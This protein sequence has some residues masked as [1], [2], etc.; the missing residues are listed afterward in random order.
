M[1]PQVLLVLLLWSGLLLDSQVSA[2]APPW[3]R[4]RLVSFVASSSNV[5]VEYDDFLPQLTPERDALNVVETC[6]G[7]LHDRTDA[8]LEVCFN[9]A[10]DSCPGWVIGSIR[11]V[12]DQS[13]IFVRGADHCGDGDA[14]SHA[15]C[16]DGCAAGEELGR[17]ECR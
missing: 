11:R 6:M 2:F 4:R 5:I 13:G 1:Q 17:R 15:N 7:V 16:L 14:G 10:S 9:F 12:R 8:G 3:S